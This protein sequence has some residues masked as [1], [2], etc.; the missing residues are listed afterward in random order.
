MLSEWLHYQDKAG[1]FRN[2]GK[3]ELG[4]FLLR[5]SHILNNAYKDVYQ[6]CNQEPTGQLEGM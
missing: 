6:V 5:Q 3:W 1:F 4:G 2:S